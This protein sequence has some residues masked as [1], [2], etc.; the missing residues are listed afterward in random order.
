MI[1][2]TIVRRLQND[3]LH[4]LKASM[5]EMFYSFSAVMY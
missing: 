3:R 4:G 2:N 5:K 1:K